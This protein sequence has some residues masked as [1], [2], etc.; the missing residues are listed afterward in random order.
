MH[1]GNDI[2]PLPNTVYMISV[3]CTELVGANQPYSLV[4]TQDIIA[5]TATAAD[6]PYATY[7]K[8]SLDNVTDNISEGAAIIIAV[9]SVLSLIHSKCFHC[10]FTTKV[11]F[12]ARFICSN[13]FHCRFTNKVIL[14]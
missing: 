13:R 7:K 10:R 8:P 1:L 11:V 9:F 12:S 14:K 6:D 4:A 2:F 5:F 3:K